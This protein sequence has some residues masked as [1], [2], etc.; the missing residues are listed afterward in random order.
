VSTDAA[1]KLVCTGHADG[2][3]MADVCA[4]A[5]AMGAMCSR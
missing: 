4:R 5:S 3:G 1:G 2:D